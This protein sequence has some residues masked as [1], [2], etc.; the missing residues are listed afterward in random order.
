MRITHFYNFLTDIG[1]TQ[2][3]VLNMSSLN[4][5]EEKKIFNHCYLTT[6]IALIYN[7]ECK[8]SL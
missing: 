2:Y 7:L 5:E 1:L 4:F 3:S 6:D 8:M